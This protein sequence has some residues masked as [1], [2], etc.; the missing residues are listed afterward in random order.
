VETLSGLGIGDD[1][2]EVYRAMLTHESAGV[3]ELATLLNRTEQQIKDALAVLADA[4]LA[5]QVRGEPGQ[6]RAVN[7]GV[8]LGSLIA[9]QEAELAVQQQMLQRNRSIVADLVAN[10]WAA[11]GPP[12]QSS[13]FEEIEDVAE[14]RATLEQL[15]RD[16]E[17][18]VFALVPGGPQRPAV[19]EASR[20]LDAATLDRG[21]RMRT[22]YLSSMRNDG[23]SLQ[24]ARWLSERG[25]EVRTT[26]SLPMRLLLVDRA[27]AVVRSD[28]GTA[29]GGAM[30]IRSPGVVEAMYFLAESVWASAI[31]LGA[32]P[33]V[34]DLG[35]TRP[36]CELLRLL[37][38]GLTDEVAARRLGVSLRTARRLM[39]DVMHRIN[40]GSRFQA[41]LYLSQLGWTGDI[42]E[43]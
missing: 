33:T 25:G 20:P 7:P 10:Y 22:V 31:R 24:Y 2:I 19:L 37:G 5:R 6:W 23:P 41:G 26:D 18:E 36:E 43:E 28:P 13:S 17:K 14:V 29:G 40:A 15:S 32:P 38:M 9:K 8:G 3:A 27:I 4:A 39:A 1:A 35:L 30:I 42:R 12:N 11:G 34:D 16:V 21:V